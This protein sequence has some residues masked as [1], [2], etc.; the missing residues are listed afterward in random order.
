M[1]RSRLNPRSNKR[2][3][4]YKLRVPIVKEMLETA[5]PCD[6]CLIWH[7]FDMYRGFAATAIVSP[8]RPVDIHE[9]VNRSQGGSILDKDN[10]LAVCRPCH[11]RITVSPK[12]AESLGL[13]LES[14][15]NSKEHFDEASRVRDEWKHGRP[16]MPFWREE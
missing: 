9:L 4:E 12:I 2:K 8:R 15:C 11:N 6:A 14:W 7:A 5:G 13:H 1:K 3:E 10:L 16:T